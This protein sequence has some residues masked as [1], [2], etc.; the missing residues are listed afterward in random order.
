[1]EAAKKRILARKRN[2]THVRKK[3]RGTEERPRVSVFRSGQHIYGQAVDD[4]KMVTLTSVA[5]TEKAVKEKINGYT[6]NKEA[7]KIA[8][9]ELG[10]RL[11][12]KGF[13]N[14]VFD[15]NGFL[16]HGRI[17]S[18]ADGIREAGIKF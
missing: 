1:M 15:R 5:S 17:K 2:K 4:I 12:A 9:K 13:T 3:I 14:I 11:A 18:F 8:G 7:A 16:Y 6:G 10:E